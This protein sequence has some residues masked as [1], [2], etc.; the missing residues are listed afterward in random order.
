MYRSIE[1]K[2]EVIIFYCFALF[3]YQMFIIY[4]KM[5]LTDNKKRYP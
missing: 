1:R 4:D 5:L 2:N 3:L